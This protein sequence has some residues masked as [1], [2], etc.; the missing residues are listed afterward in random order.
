MDFESCAAVG[1]SQGVSNG[2]T[3]RCTGNTPKRNR[4]MTKNKKHK[5][6]TT[7]EKEEER[8][9]EEERRIGKHVHLK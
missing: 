3:R 7:G 6:S 4:E 2:H 1:T 9:G 8:G 5:E